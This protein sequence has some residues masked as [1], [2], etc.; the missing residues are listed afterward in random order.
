MY[1]ISASRPAPPSIIPRWPPWQG[2]TAGPGLTSKIDAIPFA[3]HRAV[4]QSSITVKTRCSFRI[5]R[6]YRGSKIRAK[7][8][9]ASRLVLRARYTCCE[10]GQRSRTLRAIRRCA[11]ETRRSGSSATEISEGHALR[12][13]SSAREVVLPPADATAMLALGWIEAAKLSTTNTR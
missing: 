6:R 3:P 13:P 7:N 9:I 2:F 1:R 8:P 4:L 12:M 11:P 5:G 10:Y